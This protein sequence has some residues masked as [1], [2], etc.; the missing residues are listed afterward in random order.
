MRAVASSLALLILCAMLS[1]CYQA[2]YS[3]VHGRNHTPPPAGDVRRA[4]PGPGW[5]SFFLFGWIP[6]QL[7]ID[8]RG[9][10]GDGRIREI[11]TQQTFLQG[12]I[13]AV[14]GFYVNIYSPYTGQIVCVR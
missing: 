13:R 6:A 12:L 2:H 14:A 7:R 1:G 3:N 9:L 4:D 10:C 11:R 5:Q 8:A